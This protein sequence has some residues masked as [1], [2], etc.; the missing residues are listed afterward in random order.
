MAATGRP[1]HLD[2]VGGRPLGFAER[3]AACGYGP[4][5]AG[6]NLAWGYDGPRAALAGWLG[7]P[8]HRANVLDEGFTETGVAVVWN[9]SR[10]LFVQEFGLPGRS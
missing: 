6:E 10:L 9:G 5:R 3:I 2:V 4:K 8:S 7:S 1:G